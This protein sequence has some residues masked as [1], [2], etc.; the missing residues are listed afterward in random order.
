MSEE[1]K[2]VAKEPI[3]LDAEG[4]VLHDPG[5]GN[6]SGYG[7]HRVFSG[8]KVY[9]LTGKGI[10]PKLLIGAALGGVLLL[11]IT[12]AGIILGVLFL[13]FIGRL[14]FFPKSRQTRR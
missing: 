8:T 5:K 12:L 1:N 13:G 3:V 6:D 14:L 2:P 7:T 11:G 9:Q 10:L 4:H